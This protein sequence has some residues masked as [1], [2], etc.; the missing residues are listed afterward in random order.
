MLN[1][2]NEPSNINKVSRNNNNSDTVPAAA[3]ADT[4]IAFIT[5]L[6]HGNINEAR[7]IFYRGGV[8]IEHQ[9]EFGE[10]IIIVSCCREKS[11]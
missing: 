2:N 9:N 4:T 5:A 10:T 11:S 7:Q 3:T 1:S 6:K 8:N